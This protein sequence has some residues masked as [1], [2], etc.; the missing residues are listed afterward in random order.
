MELRGVVGRD[1]AQ[2]LTLAT[3]REHP[4][5]ILTFLHSFEP[6]GVERV[7]L[8]LV[9]QWRAMGLDAPLFV[10]RAEGE[11]QAELA[12]DLAFT[13]PPP[14]HWARRFE[15]WWMIWQLPRVI[16]RQ[17]PD[18][19]FCAGNTYTVV[20]VLMK[21]L[22][23]EECPPIVTKVSN[24][25][26]LA[27]L[28]RVVR[29]FFRGWAQIQARLIDRW[30]VMH[31]AMRAEVSGY[32]AD[33]AVAIIPDPALTGAQVMRLRA[34]RP[35]ASTTGGRRFVA[36]GRLVPQKN[37]PLMLHAFAA[38]AGPADTLTVFGDGP[39]R[40]RLGR[41]ARQL[42]LEGRVT[43]AG[44][45]RDACECLMEQDVLLLSSA[46]EGVPAVLVEAMTCGMPIIATDCGAGVRGLLE[47]YPHATLC[48]A[49]DLA[50]FGDAI[51]A[52][53]SV[54][55]QDPS[56][57]FDAAEYTIEAGA[58]RY[59]DVFA[60]AAQRTA[61]RLLPEARPGRPAI[62]VPTRLVGAAE[63]DRAASSRD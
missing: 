16:R 40:A 43:F 21:L 23:G 50:A 51:R 24:D 53:P 45:V 12:Q 31:P 37:Y 33:G 14:S 49:G 7:A 3:R 48:P 6:G 56:P 10:G 9:R 41:L 61:A 30:V 28:P 25:L 54:R 60:A 46:Y 59:V 26:V 20:A 55:A 47:G 22:L 57:T 27:G 2:A 15:T 44:H 1:L 32:V 34:W 5:R 62:L 8:R 19:L 42:G 18:V 58:A 17:R 38:A 13:A 36:I 29:P 52:Q 11:L 39:R 35:R 63:F 4:V